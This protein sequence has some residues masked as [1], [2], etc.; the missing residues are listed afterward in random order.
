MKIISHYTLNTGNMVESSVKDIEKEI[1]FQMKKIINRA[2][3]E[4][5]EFLDGTYVEIVEEPLGYVC[6]LYG[7]RGKDYL[8]ILSTAGTKNPEG[9]FYIWNEMQKV[10][11][12]EFGDEYIE[13][14]PIE[15]PY[16]VDLLHI[17]AAYFPNVFTWTGGFAKC[18]G[19]MLLYP[20][21][22]RKVL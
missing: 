3:K 17:S 12:A 16:I 7:K 14:V 22:M 4:K 9:R 15:V 10:A 11:K 5:I 1:Y 21:E 8:P 20:E 18:I 2:K 13:Q 6:T 19:W